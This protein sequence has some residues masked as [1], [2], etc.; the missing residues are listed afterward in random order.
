MM[1]AELVAAALLSAPAGR[2][3]R[4]APIACLVLVGSLIGLTANLAKLA[5][6]AGVAPL[7]FLLWSVLGAG[8]VLAILAVA[9]G[10]VPPLRR[11][12]VE[13]FLVSGL[14]SIALPNALIF[15]AVPHVG[16]GFAALSFA[17]P[18]LYTYGMALLARIE[19]FRAA[20]ALG[21]GFGLAGALT[22]A[23]SKSAEPDVDLLWV[24]AMLATPVVVAAGN[25]YRTLRWPAGVSSLALAPGMLLGAA[26]LL[27]AGA[28]AAGLPIAIPTDNALVLA[29]LAAQVATFSTMYVLYFVLQRLAGPVYLSQI[30]SVG[31]VAGAAIA[32]LL[33]GEAPPAMLGV[34]AALITAGAVLVA[35]RASAVPSPGR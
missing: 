27:F 33:L 13:Y 29:L 16:A 8:L 24:A 11:R 35:R 26:L 25:I 32:I 15:S 30:G 22:L 21:V 2:L 9:T 17:F 1:E 3:G 31:A 20:R 34:A 10:Q 19:R 14:L 18:P 4:F 28:G 12:T 23:L 7:A 6:A 5:V